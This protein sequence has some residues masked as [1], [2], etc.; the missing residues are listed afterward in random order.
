MTERQTL[1]RPP[2][3]HSEPPGDHAVDA[4]GRDHD[5]RA[6]LAAVT[7]AQRHAIGVLRCLRD[8]GVRQNLGARLSSQAREEEIEFDSADE[9]DGGAVGAHSEHAPRRSLEVK[10]RNR[11]RWDPPKRFAQP[12]EAREH[13]RA[14][15]APARLLPRQR[16]AFH[17]EHAPSRFCERIRGDGAG[18][19][20][21]GHD[22]V[23][24]LF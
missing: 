24:V 16:V 1:G 11:M 6:Q 5:R 22:D 15:P 2:R 17:Y 8:R 23:P 14:D 10:T 3:I 4:V 21:A 12:R 19:P 7:R 13:A 18:G 9:N 20:G